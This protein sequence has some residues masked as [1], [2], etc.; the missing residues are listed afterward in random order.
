[1][2]PAQPTPREL[3]AQAVHRLQVG[4]FGLAGMVLLV[5]LA[6]VIMDRAKQVEGTPAAGSPAALASASASATP[7]ASDPLVD[8]GVAP[9]LPAGNDAKPAGQAPRPAQGN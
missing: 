2:Q 4:R 3:R 1:L 7:A 8:M 6:N 9:G 5:S